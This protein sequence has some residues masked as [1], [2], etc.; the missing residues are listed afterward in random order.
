M[1]GEHTYRIVATSTR[2]EV[3]EIDA[4]SLRDAVEQILTG[5][6]SPTER[7][8]ASLDPEILSAHRVEPGG[9]LV[10]VMDEVEP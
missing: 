1:S 3:Y 6:A 8:G 10:D 5:S 4:D 9:G 2:D 7:R